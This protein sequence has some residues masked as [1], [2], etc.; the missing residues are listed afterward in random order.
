MVAV[1][2]KVVGNDFRNRLKYF[3]MLWVMVVSRHLGFFPI[4]RT[5]RDKWLL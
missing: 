4:S 3:R 2:G 1:K 5:K